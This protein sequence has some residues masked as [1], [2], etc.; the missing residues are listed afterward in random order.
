[1]NALPAVGAPAI[2]P[3]APKDS[4][5]QTQAIRPTSSAFLSFLQE[6]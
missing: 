6:S 3:P 1:M 5:P 4:A 2:E